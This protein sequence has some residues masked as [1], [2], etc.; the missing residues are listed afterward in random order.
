MRKTY[1]LDIEGKNRDRLVEATKHDIRRYVKRE[2][3]R[4][5]PPGV[6]FFDFDC[7]SGVDEASAQ[8]VHFAELTKQIDSAVATGSQQFYVELVTKHGHRAVRE[9]RETREADEP[10]ETGVAS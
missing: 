10:G 9:P 4:A 1:R 3:S 6:D 2:R 7:R 8:A 5:L